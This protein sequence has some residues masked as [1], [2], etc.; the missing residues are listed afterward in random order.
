MLHV[1]IHYIFYI[2]YQMFIVHVL[3]PYCISMF[4]YYIMF[5]LHYIY[6]TCYTVYLVCHEVPCH[7]FLL[8]SDNDNLLSFVA[9]DVE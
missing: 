1:A 5:S 9:L 8:Y 4:S 2:T 3:F 7:M 6:L